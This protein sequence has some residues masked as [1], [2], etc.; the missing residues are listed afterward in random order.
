MK[1]ILE[2][3]PRSPA[4]KT[5]A[6]LKFKH[7]SYKQDGMCEA[8]LVLPWLSLS[9]RLPSPGLLNVPPARLPATFLQGLVCPIIPEDTCLLSSLMLCEALPR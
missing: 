3:M 6:D 2:E 4:A 1:F 7:R 8:S 5:Q 9:H